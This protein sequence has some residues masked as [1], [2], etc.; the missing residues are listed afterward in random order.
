MATEAAIVD[1]HLAIADAVLARRASEAAALM[2][3]HIARTRATFEEVYGSA[4]DGD[5]RGSA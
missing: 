2:R 1:E 5:P 3:R 4:G